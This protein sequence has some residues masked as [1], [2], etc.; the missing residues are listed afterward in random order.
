MTLDKAIADAL[1]A[2]STATLTTVLLKKGIRRCWMQGPMPPSTPASGSSGG[3]SRCASCRRARIWRRRNPGRRRA[4]PAR[5]IEDMPE[6]CIA[7]VDA[8]GVT[9]AG[10]FG[11]IL[12]ARM[13]KRGVT[14]LVTDG[15]VRDAAGVEGTGLPV[16]C[17]GVAAP[18]SVAG[19]TFVGWQEPIGCGGVAVFPDDVIVADGDGAVVI[20]AAIVEEVAKAAVEQERLEL[21]IM[22]EVEKGVPLPGLYPPNAETKARYE[23]ETG[24]SISS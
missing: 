16:W 6:G 7:V 17:S 9:D 12:T 2:A 14:A 10:I 23:A 20:P 11:D 18:P 15:V 1:R 24:K 4:R 19:L 5:A 22:R 21:W 3:P 13:K 8:M